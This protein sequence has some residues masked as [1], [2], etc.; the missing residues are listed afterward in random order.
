MGGTTTQ[1]EFKLVYGP[2]TLAKVTDFMTIYRISL[3]KMALTFSFYFNFNINISANNC[4]QFQYILFLC[5]WT[6]VKYST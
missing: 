6:M 2:R 3:G 1:V 4:H 5:I